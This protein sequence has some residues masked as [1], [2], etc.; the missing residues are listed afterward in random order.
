MLSSSRPACPTNG[1]PRASSSAPGASPTNI[2]SARVSPTPGT[3]WRRERHK[4]HA[5]QARTSAAKS[6]HSS[7]AI[8]TERSA[9]SDA[10]ARRPG[11][12]A[13][14]RSVDGG[15]A[16][17]PCTRKR[18][19]GSK[20]SSRSI[21]LRSTT[22][23]VPEAAAHHQC[24]FA[25]AGSGGRGIVGGAPRNG[26]ES[27]AQIECDRRVVGFANLEKA[28]LGADA[29]RVIEQV[30]QQAAAQSLPPRWPGDREIEQLRLARCEHQHAIGDD[31]AVALA[32][33]RA[34]SGGKG[35]A[36]I[37]LRPRGGMR[38]PLELRDN[39]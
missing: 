7:V 26:R 37:T 8:R 5:V 39:G 28:L 12:T 14:S 16:S 17:R 25:A 35:I 29:D 20:P 36:E 21:S 9:A 10:G 24:V 18:H 33:Q 38:Y 23:V 19:T 32:D 3:A 4:P 34:V 1:S 11:S 15:A 2:H 6:D 31:A 22:V 13:A 27:L 30:P